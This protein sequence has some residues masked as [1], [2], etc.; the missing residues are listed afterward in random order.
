MSEKG[1]MVGLFAETHLHP[2]S[3]RTTG[4]VDLPVMREA[5]TEYPTTPGS[6]LK[7]AV[8]ERA[9]TEKWSEL[10]AL[11]G[12][13]ESAGAV[14]FTDAR[15]LLL[16]VRS[17]TG[18]YQWVTCP[19]ILERL[20]RDLQL[21]NH[22]VRVPW[23]DLQVA[24]QQAL[25]SQQRTVHLEELSFAV[26]PHPQ[27]QAIAQVIAPLIYHESARQR[28]A[29]QLLILRDDDF[30]YF[31]RYGLAVYARNKLQDDGS[32]KSENLWYEEALPPD[33]LLYSL[34]IARP[35]LEQLVN[36]LAGRLRESRYLQV[37]GNETVGQGWC[38]LSVLEPG[39][40]KA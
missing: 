36:T 13:Q 1:M 20:D 17:L 26:T 7:G 10:D 33:T 35:G 29:G 3:G 9:E 28:L 18:H 39:E 5:A 6:S 16:P 22:R 24:E 34:A 25:G 37:G 2:G 32:K 27:V 19:Y 23:Q 21:L 11:F 12:K 30:K 40:G 31:A 38:V 8:Q 4:V 15:L 14:A